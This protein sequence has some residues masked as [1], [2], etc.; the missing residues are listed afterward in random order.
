MV[1]ILEVG[2]GPG[3]PKVALPA[4]EPNGDPGLGEPHAPRDKSLTQRGAEVGRP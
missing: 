1:V 4:P 3:K 2:V